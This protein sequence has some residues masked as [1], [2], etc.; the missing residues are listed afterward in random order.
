MTLQAEFQAAVEFG[1][2]VLETLGTGLVVGIGI[3]LMS[4]VGLCCFVGW[5]VST[6]FDDNDACEKV[7]ANTHH[8]LLHFI[9][10]T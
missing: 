1:L 6:W 9:H 4:T 8:V 3:E 7:R 10:T 5:L 2:L